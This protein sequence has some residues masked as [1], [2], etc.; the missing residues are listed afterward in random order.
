MEPTV[1]D[2]HGR[3]EE[4]EVDVNRDEGGASGVWKQD[5]DVRLPPLPAQKM[6]PLAWSG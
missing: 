1:E 6:A 2:G 3:M 4:R 5:G